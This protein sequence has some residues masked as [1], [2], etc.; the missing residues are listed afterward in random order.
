MEE[1]WKQDSAHS[2]VNGILVQAGGVQP[3]PIGTGKHRLRQEGSNQLE[4]ALTDPIMHAAEAVDDNT[5][6]K[7]FTESLRKF[8]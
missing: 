3:E 6:L 4:K 5:H 1:G 2:M 8:N 7:D